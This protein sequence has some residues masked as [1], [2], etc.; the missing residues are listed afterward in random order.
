[1]RMTDHA[2]NRVLNGCCTY[3]CSAWPRF[4]P[5]RRFSAPSNLSPTPLSSAGCAKPRTLYS[6]ARRVR[7]LPLAS[8]PR[9]LASCVLRQIARNAVPR[10]ENVHD[11]SVD[12][13]IRGIAPCVR[14]LL[15]QDKLPMSMMPMV[16]DLQRSL[17]Y[18]QEGRRRFSL[19]D[20]FNPEVRLRSA[21]PRFPVVGSLSG[22]PDWSSEWRVAELWTRFATERRFGEALN[23]ATRGFVGLLVRNVPAHGIFCLCSTAQDLRNTPSDGVRTVLP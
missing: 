3:G 2:L 6:S 1:M 10:R 16:H 4:R 5:P 13:C 9:F 14:R 19:R 7:L 17:E 8:L 15:E 22:A 20:P 23:I 11:P 12:F 21:L 18:V